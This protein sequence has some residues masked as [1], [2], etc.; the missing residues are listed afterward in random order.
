MLIATISML[1]RLDHANWT[2]IG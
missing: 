1:L 2:V